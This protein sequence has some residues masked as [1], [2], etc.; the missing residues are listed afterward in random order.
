M[1][2]SVRHKCKHANGMMCTM[3]KLSRDMNFHRQ[4]MDAWVFVMVLKCFHLYT[5]GIGRVD[6]FLWPE[7]QCRGVVV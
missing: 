2:V 7:S 6:E 5:G 3:T 4:G 1:C